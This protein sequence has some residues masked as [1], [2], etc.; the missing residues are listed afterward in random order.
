MNEA[1]N[2]LSSE[3]YVG[4]MVRGILIETARFTEEAIREAYRV[5][6]EETGAQPTRQA[7]LRVLNH[8]NSPT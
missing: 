6:V 5:V 2:R 8:A 3:L 7:V 4:A 1:M